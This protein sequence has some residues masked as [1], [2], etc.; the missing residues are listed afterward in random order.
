MR[1]L[2][3]QINRL[4]EATKQR[5]FLLEA[6][7]LLV[8]CVLV[9]LSLKPNQIP[10]T[11]DLGLSYA[12]A[13]AELEGEIPL[14]GPPSHRGG[15]HLG[16]F[17]YYLLGIAALPFNGEPLRTLQLATAFQL[18]A[19]AFIWAV[20]RQLKE[21]GATI[22][23]STLLLLPGSLWL[24][25]T[26][27]HGNFCIL[28]MSIFLLA[29]L[30][31]IT[32]GASQL[33]FLFLTGSL[34][35]LC[36]FSSA[37]FV[38]AAGITTCALSLTRG[39]LRELA[40]RANLILFAL[41][42]IF[43]LPFAFFLFSGADN[44]AG[45]LGVVSGSLDPSKERLGIRSAL[46]NVFAFIQSQTF[47]TPPWPSYGEYQ[48]PRRVGQLVVAGVIS[49]LLI[50]PG[51]R[52]RFVIVLLSGVLA[53]A[54]AVSRLHPPMHRYFLNPILPAI[55]LIFALGLSQIFQ[56]LLSTSRKKKVFIILPLGALL[57]FAV[58]LH[59]VLR[60]SL[61][62]FLNSTVPSY[63]S[64]G[65]AQEIAAALQSDIHLRGAKEEELELRAFSQ[66]KVSRDAVISL[67][68]RRG[69]DRLH[70]AERFTELPSFARVERK[71]DLSYGFACPKVS[72]GKLFQALANERLR[73][74]FIPSELKGA[75]K[76]CQIFRI[77]PLE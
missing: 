12:V 63:L 68:D 10:F 41:G 2:S 57:L 22:F 52:R 28:P 33:G 4:Y 62:V 77:E 59:R 39:C 9:L 60:V 13:R 34:T 64:L 53:M 47:L 7:A 73:A 54:A 69:F 56:S 16:G 37:P 21:R 50:A 17:Y 32:H 72:E 11:E 19:I 24:L 71:G 15:R 76:K 67:L 48:L 36:H 31:F 1:A 74:R 51:N 29:C 26:P 25:Q 18:A 44:F 75:A 43:W 46:E 38:F 42:A 70:F 8:P 27:W 65:A 20:L 30:L 55:L 66:A 61:P 23:L 5:S 49:C 35:V 14:L 58:Q 3:F 45:M 40:T 6:L